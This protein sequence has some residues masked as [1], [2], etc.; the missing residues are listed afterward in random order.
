M[1]KMKINLDKSNISKTFQKES[2]KE[3]YSMKKMMQSEDN[4]QADSDSRSI[5]PSSPTKTPEK[6]KRKLTY[7]KSTVSKSKG[8]NSPLKSN[9]MKSINSSFR[10]KLKDMV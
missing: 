8:K 9:T 1:A 3:P 7:Q 10:G 6:S 5:T 4:R 2:R